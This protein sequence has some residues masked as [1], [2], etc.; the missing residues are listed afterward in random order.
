MSVSGG[1]LANVIDC[2]HRE[3]MMQSMNRDNTDAV[4]PVGGE[5][6]GLRILQ[7]RNGLTGGWSE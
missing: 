4:N 2:R 7:T 3:R 5:E 6:Q 1:K